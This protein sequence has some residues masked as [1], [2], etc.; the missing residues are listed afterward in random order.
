ML[1]RALAAIVIASCLVIA[2]SRAEA[3]DAKAKNVLVLIADDLG[4]QV[5]CYGD[6]TA[7]TPNIDSLATEGTRFTNAFAN[8][9]SCSPSRST[10]LT[11]MQ[12]HENGQYGLAHAT[13]HQST[14]DWV[15]SLPKMLNSAGYR[16]AVI[17]KN[18]VLPQSV[19]PYGQELKP[20]EGSTR[21]PKGMSEQAKNVFTAQD[22]KP[23]FLVMG[24]TDPHRVKGRFANNET[25]PDYKLESFDP[26]KLPVPAFLPDTKEVRQDLVDYYQAVS[27]LD[28][29]VGRTMKALEDSGHRDDTLVIFVSDNGMPFPGAKTTVYN[30]GTRL[31]L[32]VLTPGSKANVNAA[33]VSFIDLAPTIL[34]WTGA[35]GP[36]YKLR[37]KSLLPEMTKT[38][39]DARDTV[40]ASYV[41]HEIDMYYPMRSVRT[42]QY[43]LI[44]NLAYELPYPPAAD[45]AASASFKSIHATNNMGSRIL[46][47]Y[48]HRPEFELY[49]IAK[50]PEELKNLADDPEQTKTVDSLKKQLIDW[51]KLTKDPWLRLNA[52]AGGAGDS[53]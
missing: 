41:M 2:N 43:R 26:A 18:H 16:T 13:H 42:R 45:I 11:G 10:I 46:A 20:T 7:H 51:M 36:K 25:Y 6:A 48:E 34:D 40:F 33:M 5:G 52:P 28:E 17:G 15:Q 38:D 37:G 27:R 24:F 39:D 1:N 29:S 21:S 9:S 22:T 4:M 50:D 12:I 47:T 3:A 44:W 30:A 35:A 19:Y 14:F 49:D 32:I 31:P 8:V 23:F 53:E